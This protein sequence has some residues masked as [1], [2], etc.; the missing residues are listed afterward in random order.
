MLQLLEREP[1]PDM[2]NQQSMYDASPGGERMMTMTRMNVP[3]HH[4]VAGSVAFN[5][6]GERIASST[7]NPYKRDNPHKYLL[8][9]P[10]FSQLFVFLASGFKELPANGVLLLYLSSDGVFA[11][12]KH[13]EDCKCNTTQHF[14]H[15]TQS[16]M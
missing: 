10:T 13:P 8:Y 12:I 4:P 15:V 14:M 6:N 5:E 2:M 3:G 1:Q 7:S 9:R 11:N 16:L